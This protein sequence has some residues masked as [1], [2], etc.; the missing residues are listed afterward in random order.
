[1][2]AALGA[3]LSADGGAPAG[4]GQGRTAAGGA[5][6]AGRGRLVAV[7]VA[8]SADAAEE[9]AFARVLEGFLAGAVARRDALLARARDM[10]ARP[11]LSNMLARRDALLARACD[12]QAR[13]AAPAAPRAAPSVPCRAPLPARREC[14]PALRAL[15]WSC[16]SG[17]TSV[18]VS[19]ERTA[20]ASKCCHA[21]MPGLQV[22]AALIPRTVNMIG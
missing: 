17:R 1:M 13:R 8:V 9:A 5:R 19:A 10:Q 3:A 4:G 20:G 12:M 22:A 7:E 18:C 11:Y 21:P 2:P 14:R 15:C 16:C 6:A